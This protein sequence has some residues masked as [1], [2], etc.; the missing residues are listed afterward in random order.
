MRFRSLVLVVSTLLDLLGILPLAVA[1]IKPTAS[2]TAQSNP[3]FIT[4]GVDRQLLKN[5]E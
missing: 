3:Q 5:E 4:V 2:R 1:A